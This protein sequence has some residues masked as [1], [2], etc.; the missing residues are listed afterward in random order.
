[1][2]IESTDNDVFRILCKAVGVF[3][4]EEAGCWKWAVCQSWG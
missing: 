1:M 3:H 4:S 2:L